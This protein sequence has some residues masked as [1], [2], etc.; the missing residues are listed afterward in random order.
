MRL[1]KSW[2]EGSWGRSI[3]K[4]LMAH[5]IFDE[6]I[7]QSVHS[8]IHSV[9]SSCLY[10]ESRWGLTLGFTQC[11][12]QFLSILNHKS[13]SNTELPLFRVLGEKA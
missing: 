13:L 7:F 6:D 1:H 10:L 12:S 3:D 2:E 11:I 4:M 8:V 9:A 5:P